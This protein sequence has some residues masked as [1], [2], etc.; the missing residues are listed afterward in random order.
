MQ[1][2]IGTRYRAEGMHALRSTGRRLATRRRHADTTNTK[3]RA[4]PARG[5]CRFTFWRESAQWSAITCIRPDRTPLRRSLDVCLLSQACRPA[6]PATKSLL[7]D[8][9]RANAVGRP[10]GRATS[11]GI[12]SSIA[13]VARDR[14]TKV[15]QL[16]F[17]RALAVHAGPV[18]EPDV[19]PPVA[20]PRSDHAS[21]PMRRSAASQH[22]PPAPARPQLARNPLPAIRGLRSR[23]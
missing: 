4:I 1:S 18:R 7:P 14:A 11:A 12:R 21:T 9:T 17:A 16:Y 2:M 22:P 13:S 6:R 15:A 5:K 8:T 19:P 3:D 10:S 20:D 23:Q